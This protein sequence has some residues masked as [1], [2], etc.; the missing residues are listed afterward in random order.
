ML[1]TGAAG[2]VGFHSAK[3]LLEQGY[4]VVGIDNMNDYYEPMLKYDR[5]GVLKKYEYFTFRPIDIADP[6]SLEALFRESG[7]FPAVI[8]L[9]A[10]PGVRHSIENPHI[11]ISSNITGFVNILECCRHNGTA[12]LMYASSSSV[13][14]ANTELP[15]KTSDSVS[16]PI[17]LYAATKRS[18]ELIAHSYSHLFGLRV[19]GFRFFTVYGPWGRPDM[20]YFSFTRDILS[21]KSIKLYGNGEM[22]RDFT[23]VDDIVEGIVRLIDK[24][25]SPNP[26]WDYRHPNPGTSYAPFKIYNI[27]NNRAVKLSEFVATLEDVLGK[28]A[29]IEYLPMQPGDVFETYADISDLEHDVGFRPKTSLEE[30]LSRFVEWY[31]GYYGPSL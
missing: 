13:Y 1:I 29:I 15:Y 4:K 19:T 20:A 18:N 22:R 23:Y 2:F 6:A 12:H 17:S 31:N 11:Y 30:G 14:G 5:L 7:P 26:L 21:G 28:K 9:A 24:S 16:H 3:R 27:G 8:H 25:P 10:Q